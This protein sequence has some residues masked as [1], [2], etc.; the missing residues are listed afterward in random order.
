MIARLV[1]AIA[2][3]EQDQDQDQ[4]RRAKRARVVPF[5]RSLAKRSDSPEASWPAIAS[6]PEELLMSNQF[7]VDRRA[8]LISIASSDLKARA[9]SW[10]NL[11]KWHLCHVGQQAS[12]RESKKATRL[13]RHPVRPR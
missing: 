10:A 3:K 5:V 12:E 6:Y 4:E 8:P 2:E 9:S 7:R 13:A 11:M 1:V